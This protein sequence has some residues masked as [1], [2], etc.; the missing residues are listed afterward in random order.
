[1]TNSP[2]SLIKTLQDNNTLHTPRI[3]E[4][5]TA[6]DR[7][8]FVPKNLTDNAYVNAPLPIGFRQTISQPFTVAFMLELLQPEK[9][10]NILDIG[11]GSGWQTA[12]LAYI[13]SNGGKQQ[14]RLPREAQ[15]K[16]KG[17][18]GVTGIERIPELAA[19]SIANIN[20][21]SFIK[22]GIVE[23]Q[24]TNAANGF[25]KNAPYD[26]IIAAAQLEEIPQVWKDQLKSGGRIVAP[27][28]GSIVLVIKK[29]ENEFEEQEFPGFVFVPFIPT[30]PEE[31]V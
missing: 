23:I 29:R 5:F 3:L 6:I 12:L 31:T 8:D 10:D 14:S 26:K 2:N 20:T 28:S 27:V 13:T 21:Y 24:N 11:S 7:A 25:A 1:M 4:A 30:A 9:G 15:G 16:A 19:Q 17:R 22:K 18:S